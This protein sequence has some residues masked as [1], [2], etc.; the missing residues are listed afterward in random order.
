[1]DLPS[2]CLARFAYIEH[3]LGRRLEHTR[4]LL[5]NDEVLTLLKDRRADRLELG[6]SAHPCEKEVSAHTPRHA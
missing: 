1:M 3:D 2:Q 4:A 5:T 6:A